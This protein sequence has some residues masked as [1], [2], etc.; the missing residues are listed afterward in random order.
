MERIRLGIEYPGQR[1]R[2]SE[3]FRA[4]RFRRGNRLLCRKFQR[5]SGDLLQNQTSVG[6]MVGTGDG[7]HSGSISIPEIHPVIKSYPGS[8]SRRSIAWIRENQGD[9]DQVMFRD[10]INGTW[11]STVSLSPDSLHTFFDMAYESQNQCLILS[12][13]RRSYDDWMNHK[14]HYYRRDYRTPTP[15]FGSGSEIIY[16]GL[17]HKMDLSLCDFRDGYSLA[18]WSGS[19]RESSQTDLSDRSIVF[20][21]ISESTTSLTPAPT[22]TPIYPTATPT[23]PPS[24]LVDSC[25]CEPWYLNEYID[26]P[27]SSSGSNILYGKAHPP[28]MFYATGEAPMII[29]TFVIHSWDDILENTGCRYLS[30]NER[31]WFSFDPVTAIQHNCTHPIQISDKYWFGDFPGTATPTPTPEDTHPPGWPTSPPP[32][33][34]PT[35]TA[36]PNPSLEPYVTIAPWQISPTRNGVMM[37][38]VETP[39]GCS[40]APGNVTIQFPEYS[41]EIVVAESTDWEWDSVA[42]VWIFLWDGLFTDNQGRR[43][44]PPEGYC[45]IKVNTGTGWS[46]YWPYRTSITIE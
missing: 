4:F 14:L 13:E 20:D 11:G 6:W 24:S 28:F 32:T 31:A 21:T 29:R 1:N 27:S 16:G 18:V 9:G 40:G 34:R 26:N 8:P 36:A 44:S 12:T 23:H 30:T 42:E 43:V 37:V 38:R 17:F 10:S 3:M 46:Y 41:S 15:S 2:A 7:Q 22:N 5:L 19:P 33:P 45:F 25:A 35:S 39:P